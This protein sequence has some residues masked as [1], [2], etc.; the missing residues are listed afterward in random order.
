MPRRLTENFWNREIQIGEA[1]DPQEAVMLAGI[2][3][4]TRR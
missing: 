4:T 3:G 1:A 2:S